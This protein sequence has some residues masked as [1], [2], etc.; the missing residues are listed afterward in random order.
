ML[1]WSKLV[2]YVFDSPVIPVSGLFYATA[3]WLCGATFFAGLGIG[4]LL[5]LSAGIATAALRLAAET[6]LTQRLSRRAR[7]AMV[8]VFGLVGSTSLLSCMIGSN[9]QFLIEA[10]INFANTLPD[11]C[12]WNVFTG[13]I[14]SEAM[15]NQHAAWWWMAPATA[16][17][18]AILAVLFAV[19]LTA[20]GL[21]GGHDRSAA[22]SRPQRPPLRRIARAWARLLGKNFCRFVANRSSWARCSRPRSASV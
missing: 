16:V 14:G 13:G 15:M 21:A 18:L 7:G 19:R 12:L 6:F 5:G 10:V 2:E 1:F 11:W 4:A 8:A 20:R 22:P 9:A 17:A 3:T